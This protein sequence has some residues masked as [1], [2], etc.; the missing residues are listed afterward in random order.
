MDDDAI[1][2]LFAGLGPVTIKRMFGG[3]GVYHHGV[4]FALEVGDEIVLKADGESA[5][6]FAEQGC[7][8]WVYQGHSKRGPVAMPYWS[9][10]EA[11]LDD[12][13]EMAIWARRAFE[14]GLRS[15]KK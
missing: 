9:I 15:Q 4:V 5:P 8:Q 3:K 6:L 14:A 13:D 1:H 10:P 2:D 12:P 7:R 11:A